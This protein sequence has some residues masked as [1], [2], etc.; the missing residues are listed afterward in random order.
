M[1]QNSIVQHRAKHADLLLARKLSLIEREHSR[2][3]VTHEKLEKSIRC[4]NHQSSNYN[5]RKLSL[6]FDNIY[7]EPRGS[8][9]YHNIRSNNNNPKRRSSFGTNSSSSN[10]QTQGCPNHINDFTDDSLS[11]L[12]LRRRSNCTKYQRLPPI[13][14]ANLSNQNKRESKTEPWITHFQQVNLSQE[15]VDD[16][17]TISNEDISKP[18]LTELSPI[19][20]QVR[21]FLETLPSYKG[22]QRGFDNFGPASLYTNPTLISIR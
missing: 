10:S 7:N 15:N 6:P 14:K 12:S 18:N 17:F 8:I 13:V 9:N 19:Q 1:L 22:V 3:L 5:R 11:Y 16:P 20:Q 4:A 21:S 2:N